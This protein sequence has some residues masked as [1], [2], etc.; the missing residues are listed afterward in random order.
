MTK[1]ILKETINELVKKEVSFR[2][3]VIVLHDVPVMDTGC[4]VIS[5][6]EDFTI[7]PIRDNAIKELIREGLVLNDTYTYLEHPESRD[8]LIFVLDGIDEAEFITRCSQRASLRVT[9]ITTVLHED[10]IVDY[11]VISATGANKLNIKN[12]KNTKGLDIPDYEVNKTA[13]IS[14]RLLQ[15]VIIPQ[16]I[17]YVVDKVKVKDYQHPVALITDYTCSLLR[18][19]ASSKISSYVKE[20]FGEDL[21]NICNMLL[22]FKK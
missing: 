7:N 21:G 11:K 3:E 22:D 4:N 14:S 13:A 19:K 18:D 20:E 9:F 16:D 10:T 15:G 8:V 5:T 17:K 6:T 1:D 12:L 2:P